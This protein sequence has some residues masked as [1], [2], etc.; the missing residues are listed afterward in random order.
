MPDQC[1]F[2]VIREKKWMTLIMT[3]YSLFPI[4]KTLILKDSHKFRINYEWKGKWKKVNITGLRFAH[5]KVVF[6]PSCQTPVS[7]AARLSF[8]INA[9]MELFTILRNQSGNLKL[10]I[11]ISKIHLLRFLW[12][13]D[14]RDIIFKL[15]YMLYYCGIQLLLWGTF[16]LLFY[17]PEKYLI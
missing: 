2:T 1:L 5:L 12:P 3:F 9:S 7:D 15:L 6:F 8:A 4:N 14:V 10:S 17:A 11:F 13:L 16:L